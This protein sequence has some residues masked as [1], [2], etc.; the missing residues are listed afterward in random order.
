[1]EI[2]LFYFTLLLFYSLLF[3]FIVFF[4]F[5]L[6]FHTVIFL[7]ILSYFSLAVLLYFL[8]SLPHCSCSCSNSGQYVILDIEFSLE[9]CESA[10]IKLKEMG[11]LSIFSLLKHEN[12]LSVMHC[13]VQRNEQA[14]DTT[15]IRSKEELFFQVS[16]IFHILHLIFIFHRIFLREDFY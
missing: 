16:Y 3:Y 11:Y 12:K 6:Y 14:G 5:E 9:A 13:N 4:I 10:Q 2:D 8:T 7:S 15:V 1:M